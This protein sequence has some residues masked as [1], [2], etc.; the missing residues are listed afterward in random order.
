MIEVLNLDEAGKNTREEIE[1]PLLAHIRDRI[2]EA[3]DS[4]RSWTGRDAPL[5]GRMRPRRMCG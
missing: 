5:D 2:R 3:G 1:E 4:I